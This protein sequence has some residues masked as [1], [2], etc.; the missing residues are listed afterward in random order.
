MSVVAQS[1]FFVL[2]SQSRHVGFEITAVL[3]LL[4]Q[5]HQEIL[6][7][8]RIELNQVFNRDGASSL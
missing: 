3:S 6:R 7:Q 8:V 4:S 5:N 1:L 2:F